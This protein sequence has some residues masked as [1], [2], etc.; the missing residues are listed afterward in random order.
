[1]AVSKVR[2]RAFLGLNLLKFGRLKCVNASLRASVAFYGV[3]SM[4]FPLS[5]YPGPVLVTGP[6]M[7]LPEV[8][9]LG[10][11]HVDDRLFILKR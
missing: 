4:P 11:K 1:M 3:N 10:P 5:G 9:W 8:W 2:S 6:G 7:R